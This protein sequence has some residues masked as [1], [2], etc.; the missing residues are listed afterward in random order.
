MFIRV[1]K[2]KGFPYAYLVKNTWTDNGP[3]QKII[4]YL[5]RVYELEKKNDVTFS[6]FI[7]IDLVKYSKENKYRKII[8]DLI[9]FELTKHGF[10][11]D[12]E[13]KFQIEC[14]EIDLK[15]ENP[16]KNNVLKINEG[17]LCNYT[18]NKILNYQ[19]KKNKFDEEIGLDMAKLFVNAGL[20][21]PGEIFIEL[22]EKIMDKPK[23]IEQ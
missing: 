18:L 1:K 5:G 13:N 15:E 12:K 14:V 22:F 10:K 2:I 9:C 6:D 19:P 17:F 11:K 23:V 3:R 20:E 4:K 7:K 21:I 16:L 8:H